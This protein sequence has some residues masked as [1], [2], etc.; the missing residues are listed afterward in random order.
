MIK[1]HPMIGNI[2]DQEDWFQDKIREIFE[3]DP[4]PLIKVTS[5][6]NNNVIQFKPR[7]DK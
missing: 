3:L 7:N 5:K 6:P 2:K 1:L 4:I